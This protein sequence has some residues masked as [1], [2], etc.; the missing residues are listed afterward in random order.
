MRA[1]IG[2]DGNADPDYSKWEGYSHHEGQGVEWWWKLNVTD[3][4]LDEKCQSLVDGL[5]KVHDNQP[6]VCRYFPM[7]PRDIEKFPKCGF[8]FE[9]V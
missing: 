4:M 2:H 9:N 3:E 7:Q 1:F 5:C 8:R 6:F